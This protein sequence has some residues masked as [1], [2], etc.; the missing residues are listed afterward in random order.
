M[1]VNDVAVHPS[2]VSGSDGLI[3]IQPDLR[4]FANSNVCA[5]DSLAVLDVSFQG[6]DLALQIGAAFCRF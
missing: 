4:V 5:F 3:G 2:G 1:L 6:I